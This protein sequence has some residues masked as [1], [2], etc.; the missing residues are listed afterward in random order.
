MSQ[1]AR[2]ELS[3]GWVTY[4]LTI[5][6]KG[7]YETPAGDVLRRV[8]MENPR[9][10]S[11]L[12]IV[13]GWV[14]RNVGVGYVDE[15][16]DFVTISS[17]LEW[18]ECVRSFL[19]RNLAVKLRLAKQ[20]TTS[21]LTI[22]DENISIEDRWDTID[23]LLH[24]ELGM[25]AHQ[26]LEEAGCIPLPWVMV[27]DGYLLVSAKYLRNREETE[28]EVTEE[29]QVFSPSS[30]AQTD[31]PTIETISIGI[32][33][34]GTAVKTSDISVGTLGVR[35]CDVQCNTAQKADDDEGTPYSDL[36][37]GVCYDDEDD[38]DDDDDDDHDEG[39]TS[40]SYEA[41]LSDGDVRS[42][43]HSTY[44]ED[45]KDDT[46]TKEVEEEEEEETKDVNPYSVQLAHMRELG[47]VDPDEVIIGM[48]QEMNGDIELAVTAL[49]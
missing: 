13:K 17:A 15:E 44:S 5:K 31:D 28:A 29:K 37:E 6:L 39:D 14:G 9:Y 24:N 32:A 48:L 22:P 10:E 2:G 49:L 46:D 47:I 45:L 7:G 4:P 25:P 19:A 41:Y 1:W 18:Q 42:F 33:T 8:R 36:S 16:G 34:E 20:K 30:S 23:H 21:K 38:D 11:M 27:R 43:A 26:K 3:E 12:D 35:T 40:Y